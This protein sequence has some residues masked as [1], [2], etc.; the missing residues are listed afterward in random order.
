M[1]NRCFVCSDRVHA[2]FIEGMSL[3]VLVFG[4]D[5]SL[6]SMTGKHETNSIRK[7]IDE[8]NNSTLPRHESHETDIAVRQVTSRVRSKMVSLVQKL[9]AGRRSFGDILA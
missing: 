7:L 3:Q 9:P 8:M 2:R 5:Q 6:L 4:G 1:S